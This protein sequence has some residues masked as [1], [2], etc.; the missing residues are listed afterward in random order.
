M[1]YALAKPNDQKLVGF[2]PVTQL[3]GS[4]ISEPKYAVPVRHYERRLAPEPVIC[5]LI[6]EIEERGCAIPCRIQVPA[7]PVTYLAVVDGPL[8]AEDG[9][10]CQAIEARGAGVGHLAAP[11]LVTIM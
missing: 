11:L 4:T 3:L 5:W 10:R 7:V 6:A 8:R 1:N 9:I 2:T